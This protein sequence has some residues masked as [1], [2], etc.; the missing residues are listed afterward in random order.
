MKKLIR[1]AA[2]AWLLVLP[3][4]ASAHPPQD[5]KINFDP[6]TKLLTAVVY[7]DVTMFPFHHFIKKV[8]V[9]L[10]GKQILE[11]DLSAQDN[12]KTQTVIYRIPDAKVGDKLYVDAHCSITGE[13]RKEIQ[14]TK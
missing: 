10:N 7:H 2:L 6:N 12:N 14:V 13:L 11:E 8:E 3:F 9:G 4:A 5:I 1:A